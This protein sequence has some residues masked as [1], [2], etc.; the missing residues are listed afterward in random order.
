MPDDP[1]E[2]MR[3]Q[4]RA[5]HP[6]CIAAQEHG[7]APASVLPG[8]QDRKIYQHEIQRARIWSDRQ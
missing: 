4:P 2:D 3:A 5:D 1:F 6:R 7:N 8:C